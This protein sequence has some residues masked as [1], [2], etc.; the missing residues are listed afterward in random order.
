LGYAPPVTLTANGSAWPVP[1]MAV[2]SLF[3]KVVYNH[4]ATSP[5]LEK[6]D[7]VLPTL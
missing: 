6:D 7:L 2:L 5:L 3:Q 1:G 4:F